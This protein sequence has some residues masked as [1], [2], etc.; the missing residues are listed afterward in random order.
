MSV[1]HDWYQ[2]DDKVVITVM[3]KNAVDKKYE[4]AILEDSLLLSAE[5]YELKLDLFGQI[6]PDKS[7][8]KA[9]PSKIEIN[10]Y[11][12]D[13]LRW[14]ALERKV[15]DPEPVIADKKKKPEDWDKISKE[16]KDE[17]GEVSEMVLA[18][19]LVIEIFLLPNFE[20]LRSKVRPIFCCKPNF[21]NHRTAHLFLLQRSKIF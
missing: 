4:C 20:L 15:E 3:L 1:R 7:S 9:T 6:V 5:N 14:L 19:K 11:K 16:I 2:T 21:S 12:R 13:F 18:L 8:H 17:E 10:L